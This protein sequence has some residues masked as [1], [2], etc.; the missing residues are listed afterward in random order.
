M[1]LGRTKVTRELQSADDARVLGDVVRLDAEKVR[2]R[3]VRW[4]ERVARVRARGVDEDGPCGGRARVAAGGSVG[5]NDE[6]APCRIRGPRGAN[7]V[8]PEGPGPVGVGQLGLP[9]VGAG[10]AAA[11]TSAVEWASAA[12]A[13]T[14]AGAAGAF[15]PP[16]RIL[17]RNSWTGS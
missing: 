3:G 4:R 15:L 5:A 6:P 9:S 17:R 14:G 2:D 1:H 13:A 10:S 8:G 16:P 7:V 11:A 12:E